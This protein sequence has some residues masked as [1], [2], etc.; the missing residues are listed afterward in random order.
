MNKYEDI[1]PFGA[2]SLLVTENCNL[3]CKYCY[4]RCNGGV[5][6]TNSRMTKE[7]AKKAVEFMFDQVANERNPRVTISF[8]GGEPTLEMDIIDFVCTYGKELSKSRNISFGVGIITNATCMNEKAYNIFK[9]HLDIFESCQLSI[10][11]P[12]DIQDENRVTKA[13]KGSFYLIQKYIKHWKE[14]FKQKLNIHGVLNKDT[15]PE[16]YNSYL[17]FREKWDV[18]RLWFIPAKDERYTEEDVEKYSNELNKVYEYVMEY[19]RKN[20]NT[21]EISNY[22]PLDRSLRM[23]GKPGKPCGAGDN[24][25]SITATGEIYPCH[26]MYFIDN[27]SETKLGSI[28]DGVDLSKKALWAFYDSSDLKGCENCDHPSC[29]RCIA[30]NLEQNGTPFV[31]ITGLHC[32][33][34]K[35]DLFYQNKIR[36]ELI[37]MGLMQKPNDNNC[38][39]NVRDCVGKQGDCPI[40]TSVEECKFDRN[41]SQN[42]PASN[43]VR[44]FNQVDSTQLPQNTNSKSKSNCGSGNCKSNDINKETLKAELDDIIGKLVNLYNKLS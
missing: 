25:C 23:G 27:D 32:S 18:E 9:K 20:N 4:E 29:Y 30:E 19:T 3:A 24:Y 16:L 17:F 42:N 15:I 12:E 7:V 41:K 21:R 26:H 1:R 39:N 36:E 11:G 5:G 33:F 2:Y 13:G 8:F 28:Y 14:L 34:M 10:D 35:V 40:V 43:N 6:H 44:D 37:Q 31:Q 38:Q 22:A